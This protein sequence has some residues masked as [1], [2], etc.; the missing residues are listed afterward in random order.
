MP[1]HAPGK[2]FFDYVLLNKETPTTGILE[3]YEK[4]GQRFVTPDV[5]NIR[6]LGYTPSFVNKKAPLLCEQ[7]R[8]REDIKS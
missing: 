6:A 5:D 4:Y 7:R 8:G 1:R 2:R 3:R